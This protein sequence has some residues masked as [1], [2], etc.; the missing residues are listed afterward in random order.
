MSEQ[1]TSLVFTL[2]SQANYKENLQLNDECQTEEV[3]KEIVTLHQQ[4]RGYVMAF[5]NFEVKTLKG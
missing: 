3:E 1:F 4:V 2:I 5:I